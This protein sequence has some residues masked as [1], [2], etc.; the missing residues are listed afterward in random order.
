MSSCG[1][2]AYRAT[3]LENRPRWSVKALV[4]KNG[5]RGKYRTEYNTGSKKSNENVSK[6]GPN[7]KMEK[8]VEYHSSVKK[9]SEGYDG[10]CCGGSGEVRDRRDMMARVVVE[11]NTKA[12]E[13]AENERRMTAN[14]SKAQKRRRR[15]RGR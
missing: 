10:G 14:C 13:G 6:N 8:E 5:G 4:R 9:L 1:E 2:E 3:D 11:M 15:G 12:G 7:G